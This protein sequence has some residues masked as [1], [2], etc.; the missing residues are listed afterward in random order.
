MKSKSLPGTLSVRAIVTEWNKHLVV[1]VYEVYFYKPA[2][3]CNFTNALE[4][5]LGLWKGA[6]RRQENNKIKSLNVVEHVE[7]LM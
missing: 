7:I 1:L 3:Y 2:I 5:W 4:V 6:E